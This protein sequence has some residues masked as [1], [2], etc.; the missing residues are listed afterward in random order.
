MKKVIILILLVVVLN[1]PIYATSKSDVRL[2][3]G[4]DF[5]Y[6]KLEGG[7]LAPD[8]FEII[9]DTNLIV[10]DPIKKRAR[11]INP[12]GK[13]LKDFNANK[14]DDWIP[15]KITVS[16]NKDIFIY[17]LD[18]VFVLDSN[19]KLKKEFSHDFALN[20]ITVDSKGNQYIYENYYNKEELAKIIKMS[21]S[22]KCSVFI[23]VGVST[24]SKTD[25]ISISDKN[26]LAFLQ[27][28][29]E[30]LNVIYY[31]LE[32][33][34]V[35]L[36]ILPYVSGQLVGY[37][38]KQF[39]FWDPEEFKIN[40]VNQTKSE[41]FDL[42]P[43]FKQRNI[44]VKDILWSASGPKYYVKVQEDGTIVVLASTKNELIIF[45]EKIRL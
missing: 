6:I 34:K 45:K 2:K 16:M 13:I 43:V 38:N 32:G 11:L 17:T 40:I 22:G 15:L 5:N 25:L 37:Q 19:L 44:L 28:N 8:L 29:G 27:E 35:K 31:S 39:I 21:P 41:E 33:K 7:Y 36:D 9:G 12:S 3:W 4:E 14:K 24:S 1:F 18:K 20:S 42:L 10:I 23:D 30:S 26:L